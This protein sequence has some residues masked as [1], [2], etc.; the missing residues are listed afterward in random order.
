MDTSNRMSRIDEIK[1]RNDARKKF[2]NAGDATLIATTSDIDYLLSC[3]EGRG[4]GEG[5]L[6]S[7]ATVIQKCRELEVKFNWELAGEVATGLRQFVQSLP[8]ATVLI[9]AAERRIVGQRCADCGHSAGVDPRG[10]CLEV[11]RDPGGSAVYCGH[12]CGTA[13][14]ERCADADPS[15][16]VARAK[17]WIDDYNAGK[18]T[19]SDLY[20]RCLILDLLKIVEG[21]CVFPALPEAPPVL[22]DGA[23][24]TECGHAL[25]SDFDPDVGLWWECKNCDLQWSVSSAPPATPLPAEAAAQDED[26]LHLA[27]CQAVHLM[28]QG[29]IHAAHDL[30]RQTL[31]DYADKKAPLSRAEIVRQQQRSGDREVTSVMVSPA[32]DKEK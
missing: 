23:K 3:I 29:D 30:L 18:L 31:V 12:K 25:T 20:T 9:A 32:V 26:A 7:R 24:C 8:R 15:E 2:Y 11:Q 21:K 13:G 22:R 28:N 10:R 27:I 16:P 5:D 1:K 14:G 19:A 4:V 17:Q 6:I